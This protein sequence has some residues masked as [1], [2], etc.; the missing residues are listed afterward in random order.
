MLGRS[1]TARYYGLRDVREARTYLQNELLRDRLLECCRALLQQPCDDP[2]IVMGGKTDALKLCSS[3][4]LF[5]Y[6]APEYP[7]FQQVLDRF[8]AG[9]ECRLTATSCLEK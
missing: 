9:R 2:G 8:Y 5:K 1:E 6:A 4:T 7:E 3:M